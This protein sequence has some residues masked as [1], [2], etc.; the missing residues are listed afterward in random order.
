MNADTF[1]GMVHGVGA[2]GG[3]KRSGGDSANGMPRNWLTTAVA[4]GIIVVVP[5]NTPEAIVTLG[6]AVR[7]AA[8]DAVNKPERR[9]ATTR[10]GF[11]SSISKKA[12]GKQCKQ[13][14]VLWKPL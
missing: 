13:E 3:E 12:L 7:S 9:V 4:L 5:T 6:A 14:T 11:P 2:V 10:D 1:F 8:V